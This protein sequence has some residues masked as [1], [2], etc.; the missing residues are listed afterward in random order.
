[1]EA[2]STTPPE[3]G[4]TVVSLRGVRLERRLELYRARLADRMQSNRAAVEALYGEG[5]LFSPQGAR[6]GRSLLRAYQ[7]LQRARARLEELG[8]DGALPAPRLPERVEALYREVD[9]LLAR[10]DALS[11]RP[12]GTGASVSRLPAR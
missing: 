3:P 2:V 11:G 4:G 1:L 8:G 9:V 6:A 7:L 5:T 10:A 12:L